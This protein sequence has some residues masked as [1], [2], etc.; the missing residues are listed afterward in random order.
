LQDIAPP[1][2]PQDVPPDSVWVIEKTAAYENYS[3]GL[4]I[5]KQ[6]SVANA[7]RTRYR[8]F[9]RERP[10]FDKFEWR[11]G[12]AG[13]VYHTLKV[14]SPRSSKAKPRTRTT[15]PLWTLSDIQKRR[16]LQ[17]RHRPLRP[18][19]ARLS[20]RTLLLGTPAAVYGRI[21]G[22]STSISMK[23]SWASHSKPRL[24]TSRSDRNAR[25]DPLG[26]SPD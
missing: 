24:M 7:P 6:Y 26:E 18:R 8:V 13:I 2:H 9:Q 3:N 21:P 22:D 5:E 19:V 12:V 16:W 20:K 17:L 11:T 23:A 1:S 15:P 4:R 10:S 25:A 14:T